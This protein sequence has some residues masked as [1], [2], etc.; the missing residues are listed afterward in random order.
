MQRALVDARLPGGSRRRRVRQ[1]QRGG[2]WQTP[3]KLLVI[4]LKALLAALWAHR[5]YQQLR[6]RGIAH[7]AAIRQALLSE[8]RD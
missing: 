5:R 4:V 3:A 2:S 1:A 7:E 8:S 6:S